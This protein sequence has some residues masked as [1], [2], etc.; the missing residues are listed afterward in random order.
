MPRD[1]TSYLIAS[2]LF[3]SFGF[4]IS[5]LFRLSR[6]AF[7][8][9]LP[10]H[11]PRDGCTRGIGC[12]RCMVSAEDTA[13]D[14]N[15]GVSAIRAQQA[16]LLKQ[17]SGEV[18]LLG[19]SCRAIDV[20]PAPPAGAGDP[21]GRRRCPGRSR[22]GSCVLNAKRRPDA[23]DLLIRQSRPDVR[24]GGAVRR[25]PAWQRSPASRFFQGD[26]CGP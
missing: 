5:N 25:C 22:G 11:L 1:P 16:K 13:C 6:F 3:W 4:G 8:I 14:E 23:E 24:P 10:P 17:A 21:K 7:R 26:R 15:A 2:W 19:V 9:W 12:I 18:R 20:D